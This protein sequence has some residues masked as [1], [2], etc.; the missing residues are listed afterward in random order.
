MR[1]YGRIQRLVGFHHFELALV[2]SQACGLLTTIAIAWQ[3][4]PSGRGL[5]TT[6]AVWGQLLG[7]SVALSQDKH[8]ALFQGKRRPELFGALSTAQRRSRLLL[9]L[10]GPLVLVAGFSNTVSDRPFWMWAVV[11]AL[12]GLTLEFELVLGSLLGYGRVRLYSSFRVAQPLLYM[13]LSLTLWWGSAPVE[14]FA[15]ALL[16]SVLVTYLSARGWLRSRQS[17]VLQA[18]FP[19]GTV[20]VSPSDGS[21]SWLRDALR[22]HVSSLSQQINQRADVLLLSITAS[23]A[24][25]GQ[26]A[27]AAAFGLVVA[28]LGGAAFLRQ[29]TLTSQSAVRDRALPLVLA[30]VGAGSATTVVPLVFGAEFAEAGLPAAVLS[31]GGLVAAE[32]QRETGRLFA[33]R[34]QLLPAAA[35][36][37]S[38]LVFVVGFFS[39][40]PALLGVAILSVVSKLAGL[41]LLKA[42]VRS[43]HLHSALEVTSR[44]DAPPTRPQTD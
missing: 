19:I 29:M 6:I 40:R 26:Y 32:L 21:A 17:E 33:A 2:G 23:T 12:A 31:I 42:G 14:A 11:V 15:G 27:V 38:M 44:S 13:V 37:L 9:L 36:V 43:K 30:C 4:G 16:L 24:M 10:V 25:V 18:T 5:I 22:M 7:W 1:F 20:Q 8:L 39:A 3:L 35:N 41:G 28:Y 34:V